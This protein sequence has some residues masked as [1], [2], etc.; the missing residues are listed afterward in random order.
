MSKGSKKSG[1]SKSRVRIADLEAMALV[2]PTPRGLKKQLR[3]L[4]RQL[5][6]A[7]RLE[8]KRLRKLERARNRRQVAEAALAFVLSEGPILD[9]AA[10]PAAPKTLV[11]PVPGPAPKTAPA[12]RVAAAA[13]LAAKPAAKPAAPRRTAAR[14]K[15]ATVTPPVE[16]ENP[17]A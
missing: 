17:Q 8:S 6:D 15:P 11:T 9:M 5:V 4:E 14:P 1:K 16:P 10:G 7:A 2:A 12:K 3:R 13:K